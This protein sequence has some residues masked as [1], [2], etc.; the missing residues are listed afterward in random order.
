MWILFKAIFIFW[1][2][3]NGKSNLQKSYVFWE[4][5]FS[6]LKLSSYDW[7]FFMTI[8]QNISSLLLYFNKFYWILLIIY[9]SWLLIT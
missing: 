1:N 8:N 9:L 5:F 3:L 2:L 7:N 4:L 6:F